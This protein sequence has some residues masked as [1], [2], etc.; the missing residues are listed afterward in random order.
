[1][2][3]TLNAKAQLDN[4]ESGDKLFSVSQDSLVTLAKLFA[5]SEL[6]FSTL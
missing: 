4:M 1:M 6:S 2:K 5:F 3:F